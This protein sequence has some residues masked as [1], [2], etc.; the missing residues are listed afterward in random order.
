MLRVLRDQLRGGRMKRTGELKRKTRLQT[1]AP[2]RD[3]S[4]AQRNAQKGRRKVQKA[5]DC[6]WRSP[7]YLAFV[8]TLPCCLCNQ[9][10]VDPHHVIGLR[11][12]LSGWGLTAP[13][14]YAMPLCRT[15]H[16]KTHHEPALQQMQPEWLIDTI[17]RGLDAFTDEPI[18]GELCAALEFIAEREGE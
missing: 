4:N 1:R 9:Y 17:N 13:D 10:G 7:A 8:R 15:C 14:S 18:V 11:W 12:G 3:K 6:R 16:R 5:T 2:L